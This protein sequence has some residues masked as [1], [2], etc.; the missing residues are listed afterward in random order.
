[1]P[2]SLQPDGR[3][4]GS[5]V[6]GLL[7]ARSWSGLPFTSPGD[8]PDLG[9][10]PG[11]PALQADSLPSESPGNQIELPHDPSIP[12]LSLC[13]CLSTRLICPWDSTGKNTGAVC[14]FLLQGIF[15]TEGLNPQLLNPPRCR[16]SLFPEPSGKQWARSKL[17]KEYIKAAYCHPAYLTYTQSTLGFPRWR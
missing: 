17:G 4:P 15:T 7:Q 1:M 5:S 3:Y 8:L 9:I 12:V 2:C 13:V 14:H 10:E 6:H 16:D 11:S